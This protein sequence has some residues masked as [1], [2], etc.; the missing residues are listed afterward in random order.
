MRLTPK[1]RLIKRFLDEH[2]V[3][4][5]YYCMAIKT[6]GTTKRE[7]IIN[8]IENIEA[9]LKYVEDAYNDELKLKANNEIQITGFMADN[10][11]SLIEE[12][13]RYT[14]L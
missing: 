11:I 14:C 2:E 4:T 10:S 3:G 12:C 13:M 8:P 6:P 1:E 7:L 9:K 5:K